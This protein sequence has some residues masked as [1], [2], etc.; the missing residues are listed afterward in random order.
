MSESHSAIPPL[1]KVNSKRLIETL[2]MNAQ[3]NP[4]DVGLGTWIFRGYVRT[5]PL[6]LN[7]PLLYHADGHSCLMRKDI[8]FGRPYWP[9][10]RDS[11]RDGDSWVGRPVFLD[12]AN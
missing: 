3:T 11:H 10:A 6:F 9:L 1:K 8:T 4:E 7:A 2:P 5:K 12:E